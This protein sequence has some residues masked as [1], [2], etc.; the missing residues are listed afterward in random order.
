MPHYGGKSDWI[1]AVR[2]KKL[3]VDFSS[4]REI[5]DG[6]HAHSNVAHIDAQSVHASFAGEDANRSIEQL[7][8]AATA[9]WFGIE[10]GEHSRKQLAIR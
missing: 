4:N 1:S 6:K 5:G 8:F 2:R 9:V 10:S 7:A 3:H